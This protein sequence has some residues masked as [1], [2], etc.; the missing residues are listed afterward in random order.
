LKQQQNS[1]QLWNQQCAQSLVSATTNSAV[2]DH[3]HSSTH[4]P[5]SDSLASS[6]MLFNETEDGSK[7]S[8]ED[9]THEDNKEINTHSND[10]K[11]E[12]NQI[13]SL[14]A[15]PLDVGSSDRFDCTH[16]GIVFNDYT[17]FF[18]HKTLHASNEKPFQCG[19]CHKECSDRFAFTTHIVQDEHS[20]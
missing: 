11:Q 8:S 17:L 5:T 20:K 15:E 13:D 4:S 2:D 16:C 1:Q 10:I 3:G 19:L 14:D 9:L 6:T 7:N 12:S 18:L